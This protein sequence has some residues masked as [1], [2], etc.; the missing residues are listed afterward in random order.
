MQFFFK[1]EI[2]S[3]TLLKVQQ[4]CNC[5]GYFATTQKGKSNFV[6]FVSEPYGKCLIRKVWTR[7]PIKWPDTHVAVAENYSYTVGAA[8]LIKKIVSNELTL[9]KCSEVRDRESLLPQLR[10][11][12]EHKMMPRSERATHHSKV[13]APSANCT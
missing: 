6:Q 8:S 7:T 10:S 9:F 4:R 1:L 3:K 12:F 5:Q 2:S 11:T 13:A